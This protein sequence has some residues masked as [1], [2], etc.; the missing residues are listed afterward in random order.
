MGGLFGHFCLTQST[1]FQILLVNWNWGSLRGGHFAGV[2]AMAWIPG[3]GAALQY[4]ATLVRVCMEGNS[5]EAVGWG[6][7][8][9]SLIA[10]YHPV[11]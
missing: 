11:R 1:S 4:C 9:V 5:A 3:L 8:F 7:L 2:E 6:I 10:L